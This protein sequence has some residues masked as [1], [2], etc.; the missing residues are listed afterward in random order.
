VVEGYSY[1][2]PSSLQI[3]HL[4][5]EDS[6][7]TQE[8]VASQFKKIAEV[9]SYSLSVRP[10]LVEGRFVIFKVIASPDIL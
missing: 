10:E 4:P 8:W 6:R 9:V 5:A 2:L 3:L 1:F 7:M